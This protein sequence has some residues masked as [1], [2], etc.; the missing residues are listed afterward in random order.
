MVTTPTIVMKQLAAIALDEKQTEVLVFDNGVGVAVNN[1][2]LDNNTNEV[3][4]KID[5]NIE[6]VEWEAEPTDPENKEAALH[7][8][9]IN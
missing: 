6:G 1:I 5:R 7:T 3:F 9:H 2:L 4:D 8:P